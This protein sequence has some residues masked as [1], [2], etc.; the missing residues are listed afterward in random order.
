M[1]GDNIKKFRELNNYSMNALAKKCNMSVGY[2][3]DIEKN[4]K[5]N[6][7]IDILKKIAKALGVTINDLLTVEEKLDIAINSINK[8]SELAKQGLNYSVN[9]SSSTYEVNEIVK[10][11][12]LQTIAAHFEGEEFND[13]DVEDIENFIKFVLS[14]KKK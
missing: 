14:K 1:I 7:S 9:E 10:E 13:E 2:L 5:E 12:K 3:S 6:P 11:N 4:K 8:I